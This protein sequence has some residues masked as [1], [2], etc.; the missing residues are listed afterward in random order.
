MLEVMA[1]AVTKTKR[2]IL[3]TVL[4]FWESGEIWRT[5][6]R[7]RPLRRFIRLRSVRSASTS[8]SSD[9][10]SFYGRMDRAW[11]LLR[12]YSSQSR[13]NFR[14][15]PSSLGINRRTDIMNPIVVAKY[16][17]EPNVVIKL[18]IRSTVNVYY[19]LFERSTITIVPMKTK[20]IAV[21]SY[22]ATNFSPSNFTE[23]N[24]FMRTAEELLQAI[25]VKSQNGNAIKWPSDPTITKNRPQ[26]PLIEQN[27][28]F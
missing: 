5:E 28:F 9:A 4:S 19:S 15:L 3:I 14:K 16:I 11:G 22:L 24:T 17:M 1:A 21:M 12:S 7:G 8:A 26:M 2:G 18:R 10:F 27:I 23:M 13:S 25:K 20:V 6:L